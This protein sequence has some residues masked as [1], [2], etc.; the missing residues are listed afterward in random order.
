MTIIETMPTGVF[1]VYQNGKIPRTR[2]QSLRYR[3][4]VINFGSRRH[5]SSRRDDSGGFGE[6][7]GPSAIHSRSSFASAPID[8]CSS[9]N[10]IDDIYFIKKP[11]FHQ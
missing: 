10:S 8:S 7:G 5:I 3:V 9:H 6:D 4:T 2:K 11:S 1:E